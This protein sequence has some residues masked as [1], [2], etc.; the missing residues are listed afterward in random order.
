MD[1]RWIRRDKIGIQDTYNEYLFV[2]NGAVFQ[3]DYLGEFLSQKQPNFVSIEKGPEPVCKCCNEYINN[4]QNGYREQFD[5]L[6]KSGCF[7][8]LSCKENY[9]II[10]GHGPVDTTTSKLTI[11]CNRVK[12]FKDLRGPIHELQ[13][14]IDHCN[15][16]TNHK[17]CFGSICTEIRAYR[18]SHFPHEKN[19]QMLRKKLKDKIKRSVKYF[20]RGVLGSN[21]INDFDSE[22]EKKFNELYNECIKGY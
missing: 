6:H 20:C 3:E 16:V 2:S 8:I 21:M 9:E 12:L 22:Y 11:D 7:I 17:D 18:K 15:Q 4:L 5:K 14:A 1:G 19:P 10:G 13:H